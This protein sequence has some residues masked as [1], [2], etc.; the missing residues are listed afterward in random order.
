ML[1]DSEEDQEEE[2]QAVKDLEVFTTKD[3]QIMVRCVAKA[4]LEGFT[5][6]SVWDALESQVRSNL[7]SRRRRSLTHAL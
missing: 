1:S 5:R 7:A 3:D 4:E 6:E 2:E